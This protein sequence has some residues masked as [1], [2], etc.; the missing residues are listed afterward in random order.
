MECTGLYSAAE[1][2][3]IDWLLIKGVCD[4]GYNKTNKYQFFAAQNA[5]KL[6]K[7]LLDDPGVMAGLNSFGSQVESKEVF[8]KKKA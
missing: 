3:G 5:V 2:C 1:R 7:A 8:T 4:W 6:V